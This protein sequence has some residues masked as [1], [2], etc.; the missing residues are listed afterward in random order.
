M[1]S[2]SSLEVLDWP[3]GTGLSGEPLSQKPH[4]PSFF[5]G[6]ERTPPPPPAQANSPPP[7]SQRVCAVEL[8]VWGCE[9][10]PRACCIFAELW[11]CAEFCFTTQHLLRGGG[12]GSDTHPPS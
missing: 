6:L 4:L 12:G 8:Q 11:G 2:E 9:K 10:E 7:S 1:K 3:L 5:L